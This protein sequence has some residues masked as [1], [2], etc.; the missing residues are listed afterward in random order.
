G[1]DAVLVSSSLQ[2]EAGEAARRLARIA[3]QRMKTMK[4]GMCLLSGGETTVRVA[5]KGKGGRNQEFALAFAIEIEDAEGVTLLSAGTDG[6]DGPTDAAGAIVD[7]ETCSSARK[8]GLDPLHFLEANDS[9]RFFGKLD[10]LSGKRNHFK[11]G[12]TGTNVMDI[13][14]V[15][16]E[17][18]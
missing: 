4:A 12:P 8:L 17:K 9:Y 5:G 18:V 6:T 7:G 14:I 11:P 1:Y 15:L 3:Q 2:G 13:Q 16:L 10:S